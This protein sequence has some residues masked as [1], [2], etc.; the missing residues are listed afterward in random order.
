MEKIFVSYSRINADLV[1]Q[2]IQD[3]KAVGID[4]WHDQTLTGGQRWWDNILAQIRNCDAFIFALSTESLESEACMSELNYASELGK[5]IF[6]VL[7]A[8]GV[9]VNLLS[10]PLNEIQVMDYRPQDKNAAFAL[11]KGINKAPPSTPLPDSLPTPPP[12]P[13]SYLTTLKDR[14][15]TGGALDPQEQ[16]ALVFELEAGLREGRSPNEIRDL[17]LSLK[18]RDDLLAKVANMI[19]VALES[20]DNPPE[21]PDTVGLSRPT[22]APQPVDKSDNAAYCPKCG[23]QA[24]S[25]STFCS[26]CGASLT[27]T[28]AS[29]DRKSKIRR[30]SCAPGICMQMV[31]EVKQ[32]LEEQGFD[33][34]Q[35]PTDDHNATLLQIKKR[36]AWRDLVGMSTSLNIVFEQSEDVL[37]VE[38][39]AGKWVDKAIAGTVSM[40]VLWPLA[41]TAGFGAWAHVKMPDKIFSFMGHR[42]TAIQ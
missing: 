22:P 37:K 39:G 40:F 25:H 23:A 20:I 14:I 33:S 13:V 30:Y 32:W 42:L 41:V 11:V 15:N 17:L 35:L 18:R 6:P 19:D 36:G 9:N 7:V 31:A 34:Q 10:H 26:A 12:V 21:G 38:I 24:A 28:T 8:E 29:A 1:T 4:P 16:K 3:L 5:V 2:M 27:A